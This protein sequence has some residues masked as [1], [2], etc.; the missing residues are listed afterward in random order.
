MLQLSEKTLGDWLEH[1]AEVTPDKE[2]IALI[3]QHY[4]KI[5]FLST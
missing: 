2:Y 3:P 1:W 4:Y 5:F